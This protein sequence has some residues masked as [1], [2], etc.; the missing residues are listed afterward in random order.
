MKVIVSGPAAAFDV[1][2]RQI[3]DAAHLQNIDGLEYTEEVCASYLDEPLSDIGLEG[4]G[5]R[6]VF[7][8]SS[9]SLR[10]LTEYRSPRKLKKS[11]L[12]TLVAYTKSQWSDG[13]GEGCFDDYRVKTGISISVYP[14]PYDESE[15]QGTQVDD[16]TKTQKRSPLLAAAAKGNINRI[17]A[18]LE[19]GESIE[20]RGQWQYTPLLT[21]VAN[22]QVDAAQL[23]ISRGANVNYK[24][25][26]GKSCM[27]GIN[28]MQLASMRGNV[29]MLAIL[30][31]AGA[32]VNET[33]DR[34]AT[35]VM[36]AANRGHV[37]A[38]R[39][40]LERG[41]NINACDA[42][43]CH[44]ALMYTPP[45]RMDIVELLLNYGADPNLRTKDG[46][47]ASQEALQQ[48]E[49]QRKSTFAGEERPKLYEHKA[50]MLKT[51]ER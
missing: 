37:D 25:E 49:W 1:D 27:S 29:R 3:T 4:G 42:W 30:I 51:H 33:D 44:T 10:V 24:T 28:C 20:A 9:Q 31:E 8:Q 22:D 36:W 5:L 12:A 50:Q 19:K 38:L 7:D 21:A 34:G 47:T 23:L 13:I 39:L 6:I 41:A 45:E 26:G 17:Q 11:E 35:P 40:L 16:G 14:M 43:S 46:L 18:L 2:E 15:V 48:A 32:N